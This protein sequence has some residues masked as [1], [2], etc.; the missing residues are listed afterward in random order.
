MGGLSGR[1]PVTGFAP[2]PITSYIVGPCTCTETMALNG[3][4]NI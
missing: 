4:I 1:D 3:Y 2:D